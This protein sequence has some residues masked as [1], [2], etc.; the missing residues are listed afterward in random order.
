[1]K[2][3]F[4]RQI[5]EKYSNIKFHENPTNGSPVFPPGRTDGLDESKSL[6]QLCERAKKNGRTWQEVT[7]LGESLDGPRQYFRDNLAVKLAKKGTSEYEM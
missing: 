4:S 5:V 6:F 1:M 2:L 7:K 3:E